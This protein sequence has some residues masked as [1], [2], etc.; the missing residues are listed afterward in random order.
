MSESTS[1]LPHFC[2]SVPQLLSTEDCMSCCTHVLEHIKIKYV[3]RYTEA[4]QAG[5]KFESSD[6]KFTIKVIK[7][8]TVYSELGNQRMLI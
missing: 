8:F 4:F 5:K 1:I 6:W 3:K 7:G 2:T